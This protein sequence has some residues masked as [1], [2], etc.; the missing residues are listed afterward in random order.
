MAMLNVYGTAWRMVNDYGKIKPD[1]VCWVIGS[2]AVAQATACLLQQK[3]AKVFMVIRAG[4][5]NEG[6]V[7]QYV[8]THLPTTATIKSSIL[9]QRVISTI[10]SDLPKAKFIFNGSGGETLSEVL[11]HAADSCKVISYG[12]MSH[13]PLSVSVG[14]HIYQDIQLLTFWYSRYLASSTRA[15]R[16]AMYAGIAEMLRTGAHG[17]TFGSEWQMARRL[18][19]RAERYNFETQHEDALTNATLLF[20][21][22]KP[23]LRFDEEYTYTHSGEWFKEHEFFLPAEEQYVKGMEHAVGERLANEFRAVET[24]GPMLQEKFNKL[25]DS[26]EAEEIRKGMGKW[27][28]KDDHFELLE[29]TYERYLYTQAAKY[30][31][32]FNVSTRKTGPLNY[33][34]MK[35]FFPDDDPVIAPTLDK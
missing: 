30:N 24:G 1:D 16:E 12:N 35:C 21:N 20:T 32:N 11:R 31:M 18:F 29:D 14:R 26:K 2:G 28:P 9:T 34:K 4:R 25:W 3:G 7:H 15:E 27:D 33:P 6:A 22:R 5:P 10:T 19:V 8:R 17:N 13:T 23:V